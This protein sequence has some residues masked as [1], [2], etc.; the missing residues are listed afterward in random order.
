MTEADVGIVGGGPAGIAAA[1]QLARAGHQVTLFERNRLGGLLWNANL[2]ENYPG[3][4]GGIR[5][6]QLV[7]RMVEQLRSHDLLLLRRAVV[8]MREQDG[9]LLLETES[10]GW[11]CETVIL[12]TG[13]R[14]VRIRLPGLEEPSPAY[15]HTDVVEL[16]AERTRAIAVIGAG[17]AAFDYAL[18]L[19]RANTVTINNRGT[20]VR[21]LPLLWERAEQ[22]PRIRYRERTTLVRATAGERHLRL[23]WRNQLRE[24]T[25][26]ADRLVLA[27]GRQP[28]N[29]LLAGFSDARLAELERAG[30]LYRI[31]DLANGSFR[32]TSL[33]VADGVRAAMDI[34][35][36][37]ERNSRCK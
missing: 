36:R 5:G 13:T 7:R 20:R 8:A 11:K 10:G 19:A 37:A 26:T 12:A 17:D 33:S 29:A 23:S 27:V 25:E 9:G 16:L 24:W 30:R 18:N 6:P 22:H 28:D 31:G 32:Q 4:P 3:F 34:H 15:V 14:A 35:A 21:C 2:V 1:I